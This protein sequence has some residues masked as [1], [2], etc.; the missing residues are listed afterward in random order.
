[1]SKGMQDLKNQTVLI[2]QRNIAKAV[3]VTLHGTFKQILWQLD[4]DFICVA[5]PQPEAISRD[6][7]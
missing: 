5:L 4:V 6:D 7:G 2:A 3:P 1:M